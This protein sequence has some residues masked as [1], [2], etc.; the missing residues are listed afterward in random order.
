MKYS[1]NHVSKIFNYNNIFLYAI[2]TLF[3]I[4][5]FQITCVNAEKDKKF[6]ILNENNT[7]VLRNEINSISI[8]NTIKN[9]YN[10]DNNNFDSNFDNSNDKYLFIISQGGSV[11]DGNMLIEYIKNTNISCITSFAASMGFT[12]MQNCKNRYILDNAIMMQHQMSIVYPNYKPISNLNQLNNMYQ[13]VYQKLINSQA[14]RINMDPLMFEKKIAEDWWLFDQEIIDFNIA[15]EK[16]NVFC[17]NE[18]VNKKDVYEV[19]IF[20]F[21]TNLIYSGCPLITEPISIDIFNKTEI[22][23]NTYQNIYNELNKINYRKYNLDL[24]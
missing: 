21:T 20:G 15:D 16:V 5:I 18:L 13:K 23:E 3:F 12:I 14:D 1:K 2:Y 24:N 17:S 4:N 7:V 6:I 22:N 9:L 10:L 19:K 8:S 11:F